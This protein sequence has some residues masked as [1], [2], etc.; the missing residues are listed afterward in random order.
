M[1]IESLGKIQKVEAPPYLFTRIQQKIEQLN[2][3]RMP[4]STFLALNLSFLLLVII[5]V[6]VLKDNSL[7][8]KATENYIESIHLIDN[9]SL[10]K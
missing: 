8:R 5:N 7:E 6:I 2:A 1:K 10:Y 9:N 4:K 3:E